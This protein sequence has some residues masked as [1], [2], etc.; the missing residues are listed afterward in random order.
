VESKT[1]RKTRSR[2]APSVRAIYEPQVVLTKT[3]RAFI[4]AVQRMNENE[5]WEAIKSEQYG[6]KRR[7]YIERMHKRAC[8]LRQRREREELVA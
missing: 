7:S 6:A 3:W 1:R 8:R 2:F 4:V 5:L